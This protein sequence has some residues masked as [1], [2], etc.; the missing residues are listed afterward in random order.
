MSKEY[1][2]LLASLVE[3]LFVGEDPLPV[4]REKLESVHGHPLAEGT[5]VAWTELSGVRC[6]WVETPESSASKTLFL[7]HGGAERRLL[8]GW[9][10]PAIATPVR[11]SSP[12]D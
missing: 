2:A 3:P 12:Y 4:A 1:D 6:A 7:C 9:H 11:T 5:R 8:L 10:A